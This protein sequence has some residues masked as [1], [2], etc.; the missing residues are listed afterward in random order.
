MGFKDSMLK[1][2]IDG[3]KRILSRVRPHEENSRHILKLRKQ[4]ADAE[5]ELRR[6]TGQK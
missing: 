2:R 3:L 4:L 5:A 6:I 1:G